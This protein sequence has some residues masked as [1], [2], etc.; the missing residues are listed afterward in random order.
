MTMEFREPLSCW[1]QD[2]ASLR[3]RCGERDDLGLDSKTSGMTN[4]GLTEA[5]MG[6]AFVVSYL[7]A[8]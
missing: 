6:L 1:F 2:K 8:W 4:M 7:L 3:V 5:K